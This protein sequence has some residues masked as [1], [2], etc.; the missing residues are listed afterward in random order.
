MSIKKAIL[1]FFIGTICLLL[2]GYF[3]DG[4][5]SHVQDQEINI[6]KREEIQRYIG[7]EDLFVR[8]LSIPY[9][10][11]IG[12]NQVGNFVDIGYLLLIFIPIIILYILRRRWSYFLGFLIL[13]IGYTFLCISNSMAV[14]SERVSRLDNIDKMS[15]FVETHSLSERPGDYI[16][17]QIHL[18]GMQKYQDWGLSSLIQKISGNSDWITYPFLFLLFITLGYIF[19]KYANERFPTI[20]YLALFTIL[21]CFLY[22]ILA[23]GIVWYGFLLLIFGPMLIIAGVKVMDTRSDWGSSFVKTTFFILAA[24]WIMIGCVNRMSG[25]N[26]EERH[27]YRG[28]S[29]MTAPVYKY[30]LGVMTDEAEVL[31]QFHPNLSKALD[32]INKDDDGLI[33]RVGTSLTYFFDKNQSKIFNDNQL[34]IF[35]DIFDMYRTKEE[36]TGLFKASN[37]KY[38]VLDLNTPSMDKTPEQSLLAKYRMFQTYVAD[39]PA[40][41][42]L[43]TD[44][45]VKIKDSNDG[46]FKQY[47]HFMGAKV[48]NGNYVIFE[49]I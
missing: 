35:R 20:N 12:V 19:Y 38:L 15:K 46:T 48:S 30:N 36:I 11:S 29:M 49:I 41:K 8:Y 37:I 23:G 45:I 13:L 34:T 2:A 44:R 17:A 39:N 5:F 25:I 3:L 22:I 7:Y 43:A 27:Q 24:C 26:L 47:F 9:D 1:G 21:Y 16:M 32:R 6:S 33:Y 10:T 4:Q 42:L 14:D 18:L 40:I 31:N 28:I